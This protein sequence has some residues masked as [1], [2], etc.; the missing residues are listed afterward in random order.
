MHDARP[1]PEFTE[2]RHSLLSRLRD[3]GDDDSW[4]A[5]FNSYWRLIFFTG[6]KAGLTSEEAEDLVQ[7]TV[8]AVSKK[9][10]S[11]K[12]DPKKGSFRSWLLK[13]T[14]NRIADRF[15]KRRGEP[16][17]ISIDEMQDEGDHFG[18]YGLSELLSRAE[19]EEIWDEEWKANLF[20]AA[21]DNVKRK[22]APKHY[23]VF[24]LLHFKEWPMSKVVQKMKV[25]RPGAYIIRF[26]VKNAILDE[27]ERLKKEV[28]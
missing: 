18:A 26:R 8:L 9:M 27:L 17:E 21:L 25:S 22:V 15:R 6:R 12:Y 3:W 2:T 7:D 28:V 23:Q 10:P 11:F 4:Q 24:D 13:I 14:H 16:T 1:R 19:L 20:E 5:F